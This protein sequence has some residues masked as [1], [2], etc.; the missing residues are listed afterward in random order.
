MY[1]D[2]LFHWSGQ[3][4]CRVRTCI[5]IAAT[6]IFKTISRLFSQVLRPAPNRVDFCEH[7]VSGRLIT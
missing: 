6:S 5:V 7:R 2:D 3:P 4:D 1:I